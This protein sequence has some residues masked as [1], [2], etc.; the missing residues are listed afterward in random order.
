MEGFGKMSGFG[1]FHPLSPRMLEYREE[2]VLT[3][4]AGGTC[5]ASRTLFYCEEGAHILIRFR[6]TSQEGDILHRLPVAQTG[7]SLWPL[8]ADD[9]HHCGQDTYHGI[10]RFETPSR[11]S[12]AIAIRGPKKNT[13][14]NTLLL[15][16]ASSNRISDGQQTQPFAHD[17][18]SQHLWHGGRNPTFRSGTN[19]DSLTRWLYADERWNRQLVTVAG[20]LLLGAVAVAFVNS[21]GPQQRRRI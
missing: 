12:I 6:P 3:L 21:F 14:I 1:V 7:A 13:Q 5:Y 10:Y 18:L 8:N 16:S 15:K 4:N 19:C 11:I 17:F 9:T 2:G 20:G